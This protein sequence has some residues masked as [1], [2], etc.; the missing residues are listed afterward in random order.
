MPIYYLNSKVEAV[1]VRLEKGGSVRPKLKMQQLKKY[2]I[3]VGIRT[4]VSQKINREH[5]QL[6]YNL[7]CG[8]N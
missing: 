1:W 3:I 2:L 5:F 6:N 7:L 4:L 8:G